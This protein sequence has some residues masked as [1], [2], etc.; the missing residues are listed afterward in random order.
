V[1]N[2]KIAWGK[3]GATTPKIVIESNATIVSPLIFAW[4]FD[5][6]ARGCYAK[7]TR[8]RAIALLSPACRESRRPATHPMV[9]REE[10]LDVDR[11]YMA[12]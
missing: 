12:Q 1:P 11:G 2:E 6:C 3:L 8:R 5:Q 4:E 10:Q 7:R 9:D